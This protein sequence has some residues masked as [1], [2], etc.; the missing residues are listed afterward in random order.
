MI[1]GACVFPPPPFC[2][3]A[4]WLLLAVVKEL[5]REKASCKLGVEK[6]KE[7]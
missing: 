1:S 6:G 4:D 3:A 7:Q 5:S 2:G